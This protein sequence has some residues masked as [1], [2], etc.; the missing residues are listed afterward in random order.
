MKLASQVSKIVF[1][2]EEE[3]DPFYQ[4]ALKN[5][6]SCQDGTH[7]NTYKIDFRDVIIPAF[8]STFSSRKSIS[9]SF[10]DLNQK[11]F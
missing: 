7:K 5:K 10:S 8:N 6:A 1:S 2:N 4:G 9:K 3:A 11:S